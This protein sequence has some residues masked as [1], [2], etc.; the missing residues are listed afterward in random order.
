MMM[1]ASRRTLL[2]VL[3]SWAFLAGSASSAENTLS[4]SEKRAGWK[5]LFDGKTKAGWRNYKRDKISD[6]WVVE[7]GALSRTGARAGDIVTTDQYDSF[8]LSIEYK[9]SKGGNSGIMFHVTEDGDAPWHTGPEIQVQDNV[10]G[11]DPQKAG[12]LYQLYKP[13]PAMLSTEIPDSTRPVGQWNHVQVRVTPLICEIN[14]NGIRYALFQ[15]G[16]TDW[17]ARVAKS[18]FA[19]YPNFGKPTKGFI[20][21]QDHGNPVAYRNIKLRPLGPNGEAPEPIDGTLPLAVEPAFANVQ[22]SGWAPA[23]EQGRQ[24]EFRPIVLTNAGDGSNRVFVATQQGVIHVLKGDGTSTE[25]KVFLDLRDRVTYKDRENEEGFLGFAFHP[26][27]KQNGEFFVYYDSK[28][29]EPHVSVVSRFKVSTSDPDKADPNSEEQILTIPA[30]YW[31]HNGGTTIFGPDGYLYIG[32]G[33]GGSAND[34]H[35]NGQN[36]G[37][38]LGSILRIDVDHKDP[39]KNYAIPKDNPFVGKAGAL[40]EIYAKGLRNV[41]RMAFDRQTGTLWCADVGQNLWEEI[42]LI[43]K[44]GNYGWNL[45][46]GAHTFGRDGTGPRAD[47]IEPIWEYDHQVGASITGGVVYRGK[48]IPELLGK[49]IYADYVTGKIWAL[50]Y[51]EAAKKVVTNEAIPSEKLPIITFG[52]DEQGEVYFTR[53]TADGKGIYRFVKKA[54]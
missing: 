11:H 14:M 26:K 25:S 9:I 34:P 42:N 53:V 46:E 45:R 16:S 23:D 44:G 2:L 1:V 17:D 51:D 24:Q 48:K 31:N 18:K 33:D 5:L 15:K 50:K 7:D 20:C 52:E 12:W 39:G 41:W 32:L 40:P 36:Y 10:D 19:K 4:E 30:P 37:T 27:Y 21:L 28:K 6:D 29:L 8:E 54:Q 43:V 13:S 49:Y 3:C 47:L 22:W 35:K 38:W